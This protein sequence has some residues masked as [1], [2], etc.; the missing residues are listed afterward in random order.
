M[1]PKFRYSNIP[2]LYVENNVTVSVITKDVG[3]GLAL[4]WWAQQ[5]A[6][7]Q[8][9]FHGSRVPSGHGALVRK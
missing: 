1:I 7:L 4:P 2:V 8:I 6:P 9:N 5:A 3:A